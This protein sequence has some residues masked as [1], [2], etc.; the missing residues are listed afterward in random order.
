MCWLMGGLVAAALIGTAPARPAVAAKPRAASPATPSPSAAR[1]IA[2]AKAEEPDWAKDYAGH[3]T[4]DIEQPAK[5]PRFV[6]REWRANR[7]DDGKLLTEWEVRIG[8]GGE[9]ARWGVYR[10]YHPNGRL[11]VLGAYRNGKPAGEWLWLDET[12]QVMRRARQ[13]ADYEDDLSNDPLASPRS[14]FRNPAGK[15]IAE[16]QLKGNKP[17]GLWMYFYDQG[18]PKAQGRYLTGLP[19][20]VWA[21]F[22][23]DGQIEKQLAFALGV[24]NGPYRIA[25]PGGQEEERGQYNAGVRTG[26][27]RAYHPNGQKREE[28]AYR[29]DVRDGEWKTWDEDGRLTGRV[30]YA[31]GVVQS[32]VK[33]QPPPGPPAPLVSESIIEP[34]VLYDANGTPLNAQFDWDSPAFASDADGN[35]VPL[36]PPQ[37]SRRRGRT[38]PLSRWTSPTAGEAKSSLP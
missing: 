38:P 25:Y 16:G 3:A 7:F 14:Q 29:E 32:E 24:P 20:G 17:H 10:R 12:G 27:W 21:Y 23:P 18:M 5:T 19:D 2:Q 30:G 31:R 6:R 15:V 35:P 9:V 36:Q 13:Q 4:G 11:A 37:P 8:A 28:G 34:P 1:A 26:V 22:Y 33:I